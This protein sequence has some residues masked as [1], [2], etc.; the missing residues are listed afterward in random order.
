MTQQSEIK[1]LVDLASTALTQQGPEFISVDGFAEIGHGQFCRQQRV[2]T[3]QACGLD[4]EWRATDPLQ[5]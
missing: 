2:I 3:S 1:R 4:V 5:F